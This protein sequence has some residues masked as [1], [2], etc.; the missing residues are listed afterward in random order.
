M[1]FIFR[2]ILLWVAIPLLLPAA[3]HMPVVAQV[4]DAGLWMS[5][6]L[7][8]KLSQKWA[9]QFSEEVRMYENITE[10]GAFFSEIS[11]EY[12][13]NKTFAFSAGYRFTNRR[14]LDDSYGKRHRALFNVSIRE[15]FGRIRTSLRI[16]YQKQYADVHSSET[17]KIPDNYLRTKLVLKADLDKRIVPFVNGEL[18][19]HFNSPDGMLCDNYR[20]AAGIEYE[21]R[22]QSTLELSYLINREIQVSDPWTLYVISIGWNYIFK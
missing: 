15:K 7:E 5:I 4:N 13:L 8:K 6:N 9:V 3:F 16:R 2:N 1:K 10:V 21:F 11:A 20:V 14:N 19:F 17:G 12:R 22:K 18:F